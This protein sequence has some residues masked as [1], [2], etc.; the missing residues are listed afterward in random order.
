MIPFNIK[1]IMRRRLEGAMAN[2][3]VRYTRP[4]RRG[5]S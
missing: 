2:D 5:T 3:P 1:D 4:K